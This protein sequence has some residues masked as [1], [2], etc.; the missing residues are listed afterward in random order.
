[1][2]ERYQ[3]KELLSTERAN[4]YIR[5]WRKANPDAYMKSRLRAATRLL[6][7]NGMIEQKQA[8]DIIGRVG[9]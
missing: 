4:V 1:M 8:D 5:N 3:N 7:K 2:A 9:V 6:A